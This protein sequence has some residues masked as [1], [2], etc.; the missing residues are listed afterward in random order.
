MPEKSPEPEPLVPPTRMDDLKIEGEV[1]AEAGAPQLSDVGEPGMPPPPS[2]APASPDAAVSK[3]RITKRVPPTPPAEPPAPAA[4]PVATPPILTGA[5]KAPAIPSAPVSSPKSAE[6]AL[7]IAETNVLEKYVEGVKSAPELLKRIEGMLE[8][9]ELRAQFGLKKLEVL[10][11]DIY[12]KISAWVSHLEGS[13]SG[14]PLS[15]QQLP[16]GFQGVVRRIA[17]GNVAEGP[18]EFAPAAPSSAVALRE[19]TNADLEAAGVEGTGWKEETSALVRVRPEPS[20]LNDMRPL[21]ERT[22]S[23]LANLDNPAYLSFLN[24]V[25]QRGIT[26]DA[27]KEEL[28]KHAFECRGRVAARLGDFYAVQTER[29]LGLSSE[30]EP[31]AEIRR[32]ESAHVE[33]LSLEHP[34]QVLALDA[35]LNKGEEIP[36]Q[37]NQL[38]ARKEALVSQGATE[39]TAVID[40]REKMLERAKASNRFLTGLGRFTIIGRLFGGELGKQDLARQTLRKEGLGTR[41]GGVDAS[42]KQGGK[43]K[44]D[45]ELA[46]IRTRIE[47]KE[48]MKS[49]TSSDLHELH[50][51]LWDAQAELGRWRGEVMRAN[52]SHD[53]AAFVVQ[54]ALGTAF[55]AL[56]NPEAGGF[57]FFTQG[58]QTLRN[59]MAVME[60]GDESTQLMDYARPLH[61]DELEKML[62]LN[63]EHQAGKAMSTALVETLRNT[64]APGRLAALG[65][66]FEEWLSQEEIGRYKGKSNVL[67]FVHQELDVYGKEL[68]KE[69]SLL[70]ERRKGGLE[71]ETEL[72]TREQELRIRLRLIAALSAGMKERLTE[73]SST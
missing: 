41:L 42:V 65:A 24:A 67:L 23:G 34:E 20:A 53:E 19:I 22:E 3:K 13:A 61:S 17:T 39:G 71:Q 38:N 31:L 5:P 44:I 21:H 50:T 73:T 27:A 11:A 7:E 56:R 68:R 52:A 49:V 69:L 47:R 59:L 10:V 25:E 58:K 40:E 28:F 72:G 36:G 63:A 37:I 51:R 29:D 14:K 9:K 2:S 1:P 35:L 62:L 30:S 16:I 8:D 64:A 12:P 48:E 32:V 45:R 6:N 46:D 18:R 55:D 57:E 70:S 54:K 15:L 60:K 33:K 66:A 4:R 43:S 26:L